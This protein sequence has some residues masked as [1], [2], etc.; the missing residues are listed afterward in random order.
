MMKKHTMLLSL[1]VVFF[2][3]GCEGESQKATSYRSLLKDGWV[4]EQVHLIEQMAIKKNY[5]RKMAVLVASQ[6]LCITVNNAMDYVSNYQVGTNTFN[7]NTKTWDL[8]LGDS[9]EKPLMLDY[10]KTSA[11]NDVLSVGLLLRSKESLNFDFIEKTL[12]WD[13]HSAVSVRGC[14]EEYGYKICRHVANGEFSVGFHSQKTKRYTIARCAAWNMGPDSCS[15]YFPFED[16]FMARAS[17][18]YSKYGFFEDSGV[19]ES[20][21]FKIYDALDAWYEKHSS[22]EALLE[23]GG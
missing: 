22:E 8:S 4:N 2:L 7:F 21:E 17:F 14:K 6:P 1:L 20:L 10:V 9:F 3:M 19:F 11:F 16:Y 23:C 18:P 5:P 15:Y 12:R 13:H